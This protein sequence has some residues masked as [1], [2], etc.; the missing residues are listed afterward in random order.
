MQKIIAIL[1]FVIIL[2]AGLPWGPDAEAGSGSEDVSQG[3]VIED[4]TLENL[5]EN[6]IVLK[7]EGPGWS[8]QRIVITP[9][10][11]IG[12]WGRG[13]GEVTV[14]LFGHLQGD[15]DEYLRG[16]AWMIP[17][18]QVGNEGQVSDTDIFL[19]MRPSEWGLFITLFCSEG[20]VDTGFRC[21]DEPPLLEVAPI[22]GM[23]DGSEGSVE[24][25]Y[26]LWAGEERHI[27]IMDRPPVVLEPKIEG[28]HAQGGTHIVFAEGD[29]DLT[30]GNIDVDTGPIANLAGLD[31]GEQYDV[32]FS[33]NLDAPGFLSVV[34]SG[35][36]TSGALVD[37][38]SEIATE[39]SAWQIAWE[40]PGV[41][42][43][44]TGVQPA[45][46]GYLR[47]VAEAEEGPVRMSHERDI[48]THSPERMEMALWGYISGDLPGEYGWPWTDKLV[49][50][51]L[52]LQAPSSL[53]TGFNVETM[54][55]L[56]TFENH[57][58]GLGEYPLI[59]RTPAY[60]VPDADWTT[61]K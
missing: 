60:A 50:N 16:V 33:T 54:V 58:L 30:R 29:I 18:M 25:S 49:T 5:T 45:D 28:N 23:P 9:E 8:S 48:F 27:E 15:G 11:W 51:L 14:V 39:T 24:L 2:N 44:S 55:D 47:L 38:D 17:S 42:G 41:M 20:S 1:T 53:P 46:P 56:P 13:G 7:Q 32:G 57:H 43:M 34:F 3:E 26:G 40:H 52:S 4:P 36:G 35:G 22:I 6:R 19:D 37:E 59:D 10:M 31:I 21:L 12:E 61:G